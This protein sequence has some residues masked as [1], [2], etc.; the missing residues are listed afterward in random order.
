MATDPGLSC[1]SLGATCP[2]LAAPLGAPASSYASLHADQRAA[3]AIATSP[4]HRLAVIHGPPGTGKSTVVRSIVDYFETRPDSAGGPLRVVLAAPTGKAAQRLRALSGRDATTI[5]RL[6]EPTPPSM[7]FAKC[8]AD[9]IDADVVILDEVSMVDVALMAHLVAAIPVTARLILVGDI[10]QLPAVRPGNVL[11][12]AIASGVV[13]TAELT[14]I[15]RQNPGPLLRA[16]HAI[17]AGGVVHIANGRTDDLFFDDRFTEAGDVAAAVV[18]LVARRLPARIPGLDVLRDVQVITAMREKGELSCDSLNA[19]LQA[20]LVPEAGGAGATTDA[21]PFEGTTTP[22]APASADSPSSARPKRPALRVGDKVI[23]GRNDYG[24][25]IYN[26]DIGFVRSFG[27]DPSTERPTIDV[28]F[29]ALDAGGPDRVVSVPKSDND[30][31]LAYAVT[32]HKYQGSEA[33][34]IVIP[35]HGTQSARL[36]SRSW[37]YTAISRARDLCVLVGSRDAFGSA[38]RRVNVGQRKTL[39]GDLLRRDHARRAAPPDPS[40]LLRGARVDRTPEA[41]GA[42]R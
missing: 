39:L 32:V 34:V 36:L 24:R 23:Q 33:K 42:S 19:M 22:A 21:L 38:I 28:A 27:V 15:K 9:P 26:G 14:T 35:V 8:A 31:S 11:G 40:R 37:I 10:H 3:F 4:A 2:P 1:P 30:L 6:L 5:H 17:K 41:G 20:A 13:P 18:D 12:D 29:D 7:A 16:I 25:G